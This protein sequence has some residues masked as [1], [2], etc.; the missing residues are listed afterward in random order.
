MVQS[1]KDKLTD[2]LIKG[3]LLKKADLDKAL[4]SAKSKDLILDAYMLKFLATKE[5][6]QA[7]KIDLIT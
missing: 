2:I 5:E 7:Q 3:N 6:F 4:E 1:L